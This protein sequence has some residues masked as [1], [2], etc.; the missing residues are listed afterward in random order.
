MNDTS[1]SPPTGG[2][3]TTNTPDAPPSLL[4]KGAKEG[5][6]KR[7]RVPRG[8]LISA[9]D[10]RF[11]H[12]SDAEIVQ[13]LNYSGTLKAWADDNL[14]PLFP[15][16]GL[17]QGS[18]EPDYHGAIT[19]YLNTWRP[20][21]L[22]SF[23]VKAAKLSSNWPENHAEIRKELLAGGWFARTLRRRLNDHIRIAMKGASLAAWIDRIWPAIAELIDR[24]T[25]KGNPPYI[26]V[27]DLRK[28][29]ALPRTIKIN[30]RNHYFNFQQLLRQKV[31]DHI[32]KGRKGK[33]KAA[34]SGAVPPRATA[35]RAAIKAAPPKPVK[36][37]K[38]VAKPAI[39]KAKAKTA[40]PKAKTAP[41]P[42]A[43]AGAAARKPAPKATKRKSSPR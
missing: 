17:P 38:E 43:K 18:N 2:H 25:Y 9:L 6:E 33:R 1:L 28:R 5:K 20:A 3:G 23:E 12:M 26:I 24:G 32:N 27:D 21:I 42:K 39:P 34:D 16:R 41:S 7:Q 8:E 19:Y 37:P 22:K 11:G 15:K 14:L 30:G 4:E 29:L 13:D 31:A 35:R 36:A 40:A 10:S